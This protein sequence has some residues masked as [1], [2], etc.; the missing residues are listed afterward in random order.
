MSIYS[1]LLYFR[2]CCCDAFFL[3]WLVGF[4]IF[5]ELDEFAVA[6][7]GGAGVA[8]VGYVDGVLDH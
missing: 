3:F 2:S 8:G 5:G 7:E 1:P 4:V 6:A